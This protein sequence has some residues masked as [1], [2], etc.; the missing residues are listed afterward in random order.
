M[1]LHEIA[2]GAGAETL[3]GKTETGENFFP[4]IPDDSCPPASDLCSLFQLALVCAGSLQAQKKVERAKAKGEIR[5][6][7]AG[8]RDIDGVAA[9]VAESEAGAERIKV[10]NGQSSRRIGERFCFFLTNLVHS[11]TVLVRGTTSLVGRA[12]L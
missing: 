5:M 11:V 9:R 6:E 3:S 2:N 4:P 10:E 1:V 12:Q 7:R 8:A